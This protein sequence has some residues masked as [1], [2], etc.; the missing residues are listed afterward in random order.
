MGR[1]RARCNGLGVKMGGYVVVG[2]GIG[3]A[4]VG[5]VYRVGV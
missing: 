4:R 1:R 5:R 3:L 2:I